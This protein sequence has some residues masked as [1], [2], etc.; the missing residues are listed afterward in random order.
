MFYKG[1]FKD[2]R[3]DIS[4]ID[5]NICEY[6]SDSKLSLLPFSKI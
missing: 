3:W 1:H 5:D 6:Y 4:D 2:N